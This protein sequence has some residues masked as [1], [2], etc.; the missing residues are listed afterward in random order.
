MRRL[1]VVLA[2]TA[3]TATLSTAPRAGEEAPNPGD[4]A[5]K[6]P[7]KKRFVAE[8]VLGDGSR[9]NGTVDVSVLDISTAYGRLQIPTG[10][11]IRMRVARGINEK[12][13]RRLKVLIAQ[14]GSQRFEER[15]KA[16]VAL[17]ELGP[18]ALF[19]LRKA[20]SD[21]GDPEI[22]SRAEGILDA[23]ERETAAAQE[24][25]MEEAP[26]LG[27]D[28]ELVTRRF[29]VRGRLDLDR[30]L[31]NTEFGQLNVPRSKIVCV[32]FGELKNVER[33]IT[34]NGFNTVEKVVQTGIRVRAGESIKFTCTGSI[35]L[36]DEGAAVT[37]AGN[38]DV[39]DADVQGFPGNAV[40]GRIGSGGAFFL[41]GEGATVRA[42]RSGE[43]QVCLAYDNSVG[44][45][46]GEFKVHVTV[47]RRQ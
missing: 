15:E 30:L 34:L 43:L 42:P 37:P 33:M 21:A 39:W 41:I 24:M 35:H 4:G 5:T 9:V 28:D 1:L 3:L 18:A 10:D 31:I 19:G 16:T 47:R 38:A 29:T 17:R 45:A 11:V 32:H 13:R 7:N 20:I 22:R 23:L 26:L 27:E 46:T 6:P 44:G 40:C 25:M 14:L 2:A 8:F 12:T 36:E